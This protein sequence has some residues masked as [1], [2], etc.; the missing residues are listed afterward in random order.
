MKPERSKQGIIAVLVGHSGKEVAK[1]PY[2]NLL[3]SRVPRDLIV[4]D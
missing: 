2:D 1:Y 4:T 3:I